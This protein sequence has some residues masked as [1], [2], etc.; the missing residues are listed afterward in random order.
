MPI[1]KQEK[2]LPNRWR[3]CTHTESA[4]NGQRGQGNK[5]WFVTH[6]RPSL[7]S[8]SSYPRPNTISSCTPRVNIGNLYSA[9]AVTISNFDFIVFRFC[10]AVMD[11]ITMR[12]FVTTIRKPCQTT[13][14]KPCP[15]LFN[16]LASTTWHTCNQVRVVFFGLV[17]L[18]GTTVKLKLIQ[19]FLKFTKP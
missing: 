6:P 1:C 11:S 8:L 10:L 12:Y 17:G 13:R 9:D 16:N 4:R 18:C 2:A 14:R 5:V 19:K 7:P 15:A 3:F